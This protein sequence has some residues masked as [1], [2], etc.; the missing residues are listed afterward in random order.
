M[1]ELE[2]EFGEGE[3]RVSRS[4][5]DPERGAI[6]GRTVGVEPEV[7]IV[8]RLFVPLQAQRPEADVMAFA[9]AHVDRLLEADILSAPE[10]KERAER[11][12]GVG[13]VE[14]ERYGHAPG[15]GQ[16]ERRGFRP[17]RCEKGGAQFAE[18]AHKDDVD[19]VSRKSIAGEGEARHAL[20]LQDFQAHADD[21]RQEHI[22]RERIHQAQRQNCRHSRVGEA[23]NEDDQPDAQGAQRQ[24]SQ[25]PKDER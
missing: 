2:G 12:G 13:P 17:A 16:I 15:A 4:G 19:R 14:H 3:A 10:Q 21:A 9:R 6:N 25:A 24:D 7:R 23:E 22:G 1:G 8:Q 20:S 18:F 11:R 5:A